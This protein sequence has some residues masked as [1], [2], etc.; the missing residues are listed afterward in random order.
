MINY[1]QKKFNPL[2]LGVFLAVAPLYSQQQTIRIYGSA[3]EY[4]NY[5]IVFEHYQNFLNDEQEEL[6]TIKVK[7]NGE[8]DFTYPLKHITY[9]F[10]DLGKFRGFIYLEPDQAYELKLPSL[11]PLSQAQ[12]LNPFFKPEQILLGIKNHDQSGLNAM[13]RN[14]DDAFDYRLNTNAV[15]LVTS[16]NK[17]LTQSLIDTLESRFPG[18]QPFFESHKQFRYARLAMLTSRNPEKEVIY[19]YFYNQPVQ[20][21]MPAY[22][23]A[24]GDLFSGYSREIFKHKALSDSVSFSRMVKTIREDTL[25]QQTDLSEALALW[26]LYEGYHEKVVPRRKVLLLLSEMATEASIK[27]V[28]ATAKIIYERINALREGIMAPDFT[29]NSFSG[30]SKSVS[31]YKGKF[32]Y[33]NFMH[34]ENYA[35]RRDF[36]LL[37]K[38]QE[39][40]KRDLQIVTII[41]NDDYDDAKQFLDNTKN[42]NWDFLFFGMNANILKNYNVL[43]VPIYYLINPDGK[44]VLSPSPAPGENFHDNFIDQFRK[45]QR[46]QQRK[47]PQERKSIF[48]K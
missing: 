19:P 43:A 12:K 25:Y 23:D 4:S 18:G 14:F 33:L 44:L 30:L 7:E 5:A 40:F 17:A 16:K 3:P 28:R 29:L 13:I 22:W 46:Q 24:F 15:K 26:S 27:E 1:K 11:N 41:V 45:Y 34:T 37:H 39:N 9:A 47:N 42:M 2:L 35:C 36:K 32:I 8:F 48:G 38:I 31:D 6:F 21:S 20:F 10:A